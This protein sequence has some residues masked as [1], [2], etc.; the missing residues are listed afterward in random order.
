MGKIYNFV[1]DGISEAVEYINQAYQRGEI[2]GIIVGIKV[3]DELFTVLNS[4]SMS[5]LESLGLTECIKQSHFYE[6]Y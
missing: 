3:K 4:Q 5:L 2:E 6:E 1:N